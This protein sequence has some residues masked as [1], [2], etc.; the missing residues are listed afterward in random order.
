MVVFSHF[1]YNLKGAELCPIDSS[2]LTESNVYLLGKMSAYSFDEK[3]KYP[4]QETPISTR[5]VSFSTAG[6]IYY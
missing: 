1:L 6:L 3:Y 2:Y 4:Y 5:T